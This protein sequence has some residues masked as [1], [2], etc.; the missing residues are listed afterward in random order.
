[1]RQ[2]TEVVEESEEESP[3]P[4]TA[5][6]QITVV[7]ES[8]KHTVHGKSLANVVMVMMVMVAMVMVKMVKMV[9]VKSLPQITSD[10]SSSTMIFIVI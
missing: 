4:V 9:I 1:M 6:P 7:L 10:L 2:V 3:I 5:L 8:A